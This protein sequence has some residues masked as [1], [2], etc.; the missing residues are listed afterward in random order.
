MNEACLNTENKQLTLRNT[1]LLKINQAL[2]QRVE[3]GG[4]QPPLYAA[5]EYYVQLA[6]QVREKTQRLNETLSQLE[7]SNRQLKAANKQAN[8]FRQRLTDAIESISDAF[9]LLGSD[10]KII[11][12]NSNFAAFLHTSNLPLETVINPKALS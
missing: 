9:F 2:M 11:L 3:E 1:K 12:Q 4:N 10:G 6:E 8:L 5:F 7:R